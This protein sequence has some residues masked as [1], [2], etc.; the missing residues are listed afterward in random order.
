MK[1]GNL[2]KNLTI[3]HPSSPLVFRLPSP[4]FNPLILTPFPKCP[5]KAEM[6]KKCPRPEKWARTQNLLKGKGNSSLPL[7]LS[8]SLSLYLSIY[9]LLYRSL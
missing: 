1:K 7:S 5:Y 9:L 8:L 3:E 6:V 2:Q 4:P